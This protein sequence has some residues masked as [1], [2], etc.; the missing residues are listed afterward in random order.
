MFRF[1][2]IAWN[3]SWDRACATAA[4][5]GDFGQDRID[6]EPVL[7]RPGLQVYTRGA[8]PGANEA[9]HLQG[10]LGVV[11]GKLFRRCDSETAPA[12]HLA[13]TAAENRSILESEGRALVNG[14]WGRY[15]AI[16]QTASGSTRVLRDPSGALP[17]FRI[18]H[19]G[20][21]IVFSWLEDALAS[22]G[23]ARPWAVQWDAFRAFLLGGKLAGRQTALEGVLQILPGESIDLHDQGSTLLWNALDFARAPN[24]CSADEAVQRIRQHVLTCTM[25]WAS[26]YDSLLVRLSGGVDSSILFSCL[27]PGKTPA[28]VIG[29]NYYSEGSDSDERVYARLTAATVGRDLV[30]R[31]RDPAFDLGQVLR[32]ART[33]EPVRYTGWLNGAADLRIATA[34]GAPAIFTGAGGDSVFFEFADWWPAADY[35][36]IRGL[37]AGFPVAAMDAARLGKVSVWRAM[38]QAF[39]ERVAPSR[40][41]THLLGASPLLAEEVR[42]AV[43]DWRR[44]IHPAQRDAT[45]VP[46]GKRMQTM[47]ATHPVTYYSPFEQEA[48]PE[49]VNP[50]LSQPLL[51]LCLSLP[52]YLLTQGGYGRALARRA[53]AQDLPPQIV[54]RRSKGGLA[55]HVSEVLMRNIQ[56]VRAMLLDGQLARRGLLNRANVEEVLSGRPSAI[57]GHASQIHGLVAAQA[58]VDRWVS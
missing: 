56:E 58:W 29:V 16:F 53:F 54:N 21:S 40:L 8:K 34:Y 18:H 45:D 31:Q 50:L 7:L 5:L 13:L 12:R 9:I 15:V 37:D 43:E 47:S 55:E 51:E 52:T 44:L 1:I 36:A 4:R 35:L 10:G 38:G 30:E 42:L 32:S 26:C 48:A 25:A 22:L 49:L 23:T 19:E 39:K 17:C 11:L 6:W 3:P 24:H 57:A 28:D 27:A 46:I 33:C 20:V 41:E 14:F 2:A